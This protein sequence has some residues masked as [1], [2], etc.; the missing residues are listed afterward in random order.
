MTNSN[1]FVKITK[2][3]FVCSL[4]FFISSC[5]SSLTQK[6]IPFTINEKVYFQWADGKD[7][8][9][10]TTITVKGY[11]KSTNLSFSKIYFQNQAFEVVPEFNGNDFV[12]SATKTE[13]YKPDVVVS[14]DP[15]D[16]YGNKPP[17][18]S[19]SKIPF[20][21]ENDEAVLAYSVNG[22]ESFYKVTGIEKMD[23]DFRP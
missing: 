9:R 14:R 11:A 1:P 16:E 8:T 13:L 2:V 21:L 7:G 22:Q 19:K 10:G 15:A 4:F 5:K 12:L 3:V 18:A 6:T 20:D 17:G 23:T